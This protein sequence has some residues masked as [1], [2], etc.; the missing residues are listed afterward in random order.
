MKKILFIFLGVFFILI[1]GLQ[2][3]NYHFSPK[4]SGEIDLEKLNSDTD[5]FFDDFGI[6]HIYA[7]NAE[8]AYFS[9]GYIHAQERLFQMEMMRRVGTGTLAEI[10]GED[11]VEVDKFFRTLGIPKHAKWSDAVWANN[12]K[13]PWKA[14]TN[15]YLSGINSYIEN[16]KLPIEYTLLGTKPRLFTTEDIHGIIGYMSFTFAMAMKT[17]PLV[18]KMARTLTPAHMEVLSIHTLPSHH[19]IP[20]N[21]PKRTDEN[22]IMSDNLMSMLDKIPV[23]LLEGSN[24]WVIS[25]QKTASGEVLFLN[26]THIGFSQPSVW[27][28]AHIEYPGYSYYGNHLAGVPFGLVGHTR[29][30][31]YGLTMF[32]NDDQDFYEE[33]VDPLKPNHTIFN[34]GYIPIRNRTEK[35]AVKG[36]STIEFEI[37]ESYHGPI[38]NEVIPEIG[39]LTSNPVASWWVYLLEPTK[40]LEAT[41]KLAHAADIHEVEHAVRLIHAPGLN[42]MYGDK[43]GNIAWWAAAK[44]PNR[45]KHVNSKIFLNGSTDKDEPK[46]WL[47]FE[48]NPMSINPASGFVATANNQPDTLSNG[49]FFPGYYYPGDRWDRI[50]KV[51]NSRNDWTQEDIKNLQLESINEKHPINAKSMIDAVNPNLFEGFETI[52]LALSKWNGDHK[53]S[54]TAPTLYYKW[55][56]HTLKLM[57]SDELGNED[58]EN[59]LSTFLYI[60]S[61]PNLISTENSPWW[62]NVN[63]SQVESRNEIIEKAL[64]ISLKELSNQFGSNC[65]DWT[66]EKA[67]VLVHEHPLGAKKPLDRIF[68]VKSSAVPANEEAVNKL[69]FKLNGSGIYHVKSGAAMRIIIDFANVESSESIIP[70]GQSGNVFSKHYKDQSEMYANGQYRPQ[71]MNE[72]FIKSNSKNHLKLRAKIKI[73]E[74]SNTTK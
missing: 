67:V 14:A 7:Q 49:V 57:M 11:L 51:I 37:N 5:I 12:K 29:T 45:P 27:F 13:S 64:T 66:W 8:D 69:A 70:T 58:F 40:A 23:P 9:L 72:S 38:M 16:G 53:L 15:A 34:N 50:A 17:D 19:V 42:V 61:V 10:L 36:Q 35:I 6:P 41:Y 25:P 71:L 30:H 31:S 56:Y 43:K 55:L 26:D 44:L 73:Q 3:L 54:N 63:T 65:E 24:A 60:R 20:L 46:G 33:Q 68:N 59:F 22:A 47:P 74:S 39:K 1:V 62:N 2:I 32:E 4:Y 21:Y 52:K 28:E 48:E 18:T